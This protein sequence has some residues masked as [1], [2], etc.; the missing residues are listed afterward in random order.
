MA[1]AG[2]GEVQQADA[3]QGNYQWLPQFGPAASAAGTLLRGARDG[4]GNRLLMT[5]MAMLTFPLGLWGV[6]LLI[7]MPF[8]GPGDLSSTWPVFLLAWSFFGMT[9][10]IAI[11]YGEWPARLR[12]LWL[13]SA[14]NRAEGWRLLE[15]SLWQDALLIAGCSTM[16]SLLV[17]LLGTLAVKY[18]AFYVAGC[19][20]MALFVSYCT[21][22]IRA[23]GTRRIVLMLLILLVV[24]V[25]CAVLTIVTNSSRP[26]GIFWLLPAIALLTLAARTLAHRRCLRIDWCAIRPA[27]PARRA[28]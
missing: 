18:L 14:G 6:M 8:N 11:W 24:F 20:S 1:L 13:R 4:L 3:S 27:R 26:N 5:L 7:G 9:L 23:A 12:V 15:R 10:H 28:V 22:W 2:M 25:C 17:Q 19:L 16:L 21:F